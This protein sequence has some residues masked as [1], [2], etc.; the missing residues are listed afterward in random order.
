MTPG[1]TPTKAFRSPL[2]TI[3][4]LWWGRVLSPFWALRGSLAGHQAVPR[5]QAGPAGSSCSQ[6]CS[7]LGFSPKAQE[8]GSSPPA[9]PGLVSA[10]TSGTAAR[11]ARERG[12][13]WNQSSRTR[14]AHSIP[15]KGTKPLW[16]NPG[17]FLLTMVHWKSTRILISSYI[18][19]RKS[20]E[21]WFSVGKLLETK[22]TIHLNSIC[23][24]RHSSGQVNASLSHFSM[25]SLLILPI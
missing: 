5:L 6:H 14:T 24:I 18:I 11:A 7:A 25:S 3:L 9:S 4:P 16:N 13:P 21:L 23:S 12:Q 8:R 19:V 15:P 2:Q 1:P 22:Y 17:A 10:A 20:E